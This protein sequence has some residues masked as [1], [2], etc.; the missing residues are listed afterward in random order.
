MLRHNHQRWSMIRQS[1]QQRDDVDYNNVNNIIAIRKYKEKVK[2]NMAYDNGKCM[3][4][5]R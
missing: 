4:I 3:I 2:Y 1:S 5:T